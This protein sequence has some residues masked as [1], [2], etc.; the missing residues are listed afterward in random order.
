[1]RRHCSGQ[2]DSWIQTALSRYL[3]IPGLPFTEFKVT[4]MITSELNL[5]LLESQHMK[6][7]AG[8]MVLSLPFHQSLIPVNLT[9][10][11]QMRMDR[12]LRTERRVDLDCRRESEYGRRRKRWRLGLACACEE[13]TRRDSADRVAAAPSM[14]LFNALALALAST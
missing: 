9:E 7:N 14:L 8:H 1:M 11:Q 13:E 10:P 6:M 2:N 3:L 5:T 12:L 4:I